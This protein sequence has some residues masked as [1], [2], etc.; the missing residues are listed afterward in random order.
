MRKNA[1]SRYVASLIAVTASDDEAPQPM[2]YA[3]VK[4]TA[5]EAMDEVRVLAGPI[6]KIEL[7]GSLSSRTARALK[8]KPDA[9]RVL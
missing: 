6:A 2:I 4:H 7:A 3:V 1:P 5:Q 9:V 8:L